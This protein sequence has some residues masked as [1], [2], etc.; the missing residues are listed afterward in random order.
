MV[1]DRFHTST[2]SIRVSADE[3]FTAK[4]QRSGSSVFG[5]PFVGRIGFAVQD[6][7]RSA[8]IVIVF[9]DDG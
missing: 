7:R 6:H 1:S 9:S 5:G 2:A 4:H 3:V 8:G